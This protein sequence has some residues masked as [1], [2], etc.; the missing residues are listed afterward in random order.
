M[1]AKNSEPKQKRSQIIYSSILDGATVCFDKLGFEKTTTNKIAEVVGVSIGSFYRYFPDKKSLFKTLTNRFT[2]NNRKEF[3]TWLEGLNGVPL[4]ETVTTMMTRSI[5]Q[6]LGEKIFFKIILIKMFDVEMSEEIF[7]A[8]RRLAI[9]V[10]HRLIK[11]YPE[12]ALASHQAALEED[13]CSGFHAFMSTIH[14]AAIKGASP[15]EVQ[16]LKENMSNLFIGIIKKHY[17]P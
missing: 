16:R 7:E 4:E 6:F 3:E 13:L 17:S 2:E 8:R 15:D 14:A 11:N 5:D 9:S 1:K 12:S 10:A